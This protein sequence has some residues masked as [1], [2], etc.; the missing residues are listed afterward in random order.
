LR[1]TKVKVADAGAPGEPDGAALALG[2]ADGVPLGSG[3]GAADG[4]ALSVG[5]L[6]VGVMVAFAEGDA[7]ATREG[8]GD[9]V[10]EPSRPTMIRSVTATTSTNRPV[11]A[12]TTVRRVRSLTGSSH[13]CVRASYPTP[14][15]E[16]KRPAEAGRFRSRGES[17]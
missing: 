3:V 14:P 15:Q 12:A 1:P 9:A 2:I 17:G 11:R 10:P 8:L 13:A 6:S 4:A 16:S 5:V 7:T